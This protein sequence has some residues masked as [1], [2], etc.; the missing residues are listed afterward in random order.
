MATVDEYGQLLLSES[1]RTPT[2]AWAILSGRQIDPDRI[3][4]SEEHARI[5]AAMELESPDD[6]VPVLVKGDHIE[7]R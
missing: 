6:V 1:D 3:F 4:P 7:R 2:Q 5:R